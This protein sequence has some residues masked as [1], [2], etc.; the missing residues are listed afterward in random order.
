MRQRLRD[1]RGFTLIE[2]IV[3]MAS[4]TVILGATFMLVQIA[5][6]SQVDASTRVASIQQ[7]RAAVNDLT[8]SVRA[9]TCL[10]DGSAAFIS[11]TDTSMQFYTSV[12]A[13][14]TDYQRVQ[15]RTISW[16]ADPT[17]D[18]GRITEVTEQ[19][20]GRPPNVTG[21][22]AP[23]T[24]V[25]ASDVKLI[26]STPFLRY[27]TFQGNPASA[28]LQLPTPVSAGNRFR[29]IKVEFSFQ[30]ST[31]RANQANPELRFINSAT[32]RTA[33]PDAQEGTLPCN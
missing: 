30:A 2:L 7:G 8:R 13:A 31:D 6:R 24:R 10:G 16:V 22:S 4:G 17:G 14:Q 28:T 32:A 1:E 15:R 18:M 3:G 33:D 21:W 20:T 26:P 12:G 27:Y 5:I 23:V 29:I 25:L 19:G 11:A 9:Q